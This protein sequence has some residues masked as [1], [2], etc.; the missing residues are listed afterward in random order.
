LRDLRDLG[1]E[2]LET[3]DRVS[4]SSTVELL[5]RFGNGLLHRGHGLATKLLGGGFFWHRRLPAAL[6]HRDFDGNMGTPNRGGK[7]TNN[8]C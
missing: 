1:C 3:L 6:D 2:L 5:S 8:D 7:Q 4:V